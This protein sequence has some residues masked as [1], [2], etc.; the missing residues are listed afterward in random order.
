MNR[1]E[2]RRQEKVQKPTS[3][4][5]GLAVRALL[6]EAIGHHRAGRYGAAEPLYEQVLAADPTHAEALHLL[7]LTAY[8]TGRLERAAGLLA[9]AVQADASQAM[10]WFNY[11][12]VLQKRGA[13]S[14]ALAAY[15]Q[16]L[17]LNP[18]Y[19]EAHSNRGNVLRE[20]GRVEEAVAAYRAALSFRPQY[21][22]ASNNL[23]VALKEQG[24]LREAQAAYEQALSLAPG[25]LE[26]HA[27]LGSLFMEEGRLAE[28][29]AC[30]ERALRLKP[31]YV[32]ALYH[33]AFVHLWQRRV[34]RAL[35]CLRRSA[36]LKHNRGQAVALATLSASRVKHDAEQMQYLAAEGRLDSS[37]RP[38]LDALLRLR[39]RIDQGQARLDL[40]SP[41]AESIAASFNRIVHYG[42]APELPTGAINPAL[43]VPAIEARYNATRPEVTYID[44]LLTEDALA[45]LRRFCLEST[46]WKR[47]YD[48]GYLGAFL[49]DG[50]SCPLLL[51]IAEELRLTFPGIFHEHRL[52]QAWAFKY[53][54]TRTGLNIHADAAAV[55]VNFWLT[56]DEAN[57]DPESGGL[58]VWDKEAPADWNF[59]AYN[60][61]KNE[62]AVRAFLEASGAKA[63]TIPYRA[64]RAI[65]FNS[66]LFHETDRFHFKDDYTS[67]RL[68]VTLL[69]GRRHAG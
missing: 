66:D 51:Q 6:Q 56:P 13:G 10:Y 26:A 8:Q 47:D 68:N 64:N 24:N 25:H 43:D 57:L 69:Y 9:R 1:A 50:F 45:S 2:R 23:G 12:V 61:T 31:D 38:Y 67:R 7:G 5:S 42:D 52:T 49:G 33:L 55:N 44:H 63:I 20:Q 21:A 59:R 53:D 15:D 34:D 35:A 27:N 65:V 16:A 58:T 11:G 29:E 22:E 60:S 17:R 39:A 62:P 40:S 19:P 46:I 28:A 37:D 36:D 18:R 32:N 14:E 30:F 4:Q 41:E 48:N 54:S 3:T